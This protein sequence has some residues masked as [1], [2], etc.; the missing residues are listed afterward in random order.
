MIPAST[1]NESM[2]NIYSTS[3]TYRITCGSTHDDV[4]QSVYS[5]KN[6]SWITIST[7]RFFNL[8][9]RPL[10]SKHSWIDLDD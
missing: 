2:G 7:F 10:L 8:L 9:W 3:F 6:N 1:S 4:L 5:K